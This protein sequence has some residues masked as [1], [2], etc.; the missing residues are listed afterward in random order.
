MGEG[1]GGWVKLYPIFF[2]FLEFF[3]FAKPLNKS[4]CVF[5]NYMQDMKRKMVP[6]TQ[7]SNQTQ[8]SSLELDST[9]TTLTQVPS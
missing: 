6:G 2:G 7:S 1:V 4:D 5:Q 9:T 8:T 3:N